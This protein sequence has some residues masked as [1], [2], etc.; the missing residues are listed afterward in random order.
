MKSNF[1][2]SGKNLSKTEKM[3]KN[4]TKE[5]ESFE[6]RFEEQNNYEEDILRK[7]QKEQKFLEDY[8]SKL[9]KV[10]KE[11]YQKKGKNLTTSI[12][13]STKDFC[14]MENSLIVPPHLIDPLIFAYEEKIEILEEEVS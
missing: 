11:I 6:N 2:K 5:I 3:Y 9:L 12:K 7:F 4:L 8:N 14:D 10:K 13:E 1:E